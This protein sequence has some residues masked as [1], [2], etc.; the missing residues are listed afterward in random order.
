LARHPKRI[1]Y[2]ESAMAVVTLLTDFGTES[3]YAGVMKGVILSTDPF[4]RIVD[5]SHRIAPRDIL[6]AALTLGASYMYFPKGTVHVAVVDPGVGGGR[7]IL[8]AEA[9]DWTFLAP[10]NGLL[11]LV[12]Q[13]AGIRRMV[14]VERESFFLPRVS[15]TFHG[16]D[17]FAPLAGR[18]SAGLDI[19]ELGP[20]LK[21]GDMQQLEI[22]RAAVV[23]GE[24]RGIIMGFDRFGNIL[25]NIESADLQRMTDAGARHKLD[26]HIGA[27][28]ISGLAPNYASV[29]AGRPVAVIGSRGFLEIA[30]NGGSA[31]ELLGGR[32]GDP[33]V[34]KT[35]R[36]GPPDEDV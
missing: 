10:D 31:R 5:I 17:I 13:K 24:L 19:T 21:A 36:R 20:P 25:T 28:H 7:A 30:V 3:E 18:L 16:R 4:A 26:I 27:R 9:G 12:A 2:Y 1:D 23:R 14:R 6:Q 35:A 32:S 34:V 11:S 22:P 8:A 29:P 33:V 15:A